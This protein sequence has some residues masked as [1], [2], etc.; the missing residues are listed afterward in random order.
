MAP[1]VDSNGLTAWERR[2]AENAKVNNEILNES[3]N[4]GGKRKRDD[5]FV[6][7]GFND[8]PQAAAATREKRLRVRGDLQLSDMKVD[9]RW[10]GSLDG[11]QGLAK[12][13]AGG[14][15]PGVRTFTDD[16]IQETTDKELKRLR[17]EMNSLALYDKFDV[18]DL[19]L[20]KER[21]YA[22]AFHPTEDKPLVFAGDKEGRLGIFDA[23]Q[24]PD[25]AVKE[26][27]ADDHE[28]PPEPVILGFQP[29]T[30]TISGLFCLDTDPS[31]VY[32]ASY[33]T[34][35]RKLDLHA[36]KSVEVYAPADGDDSD[37]AIS[38]MDFASDSPH[39]VFFS[40]L[41]GALGRHDLRAAPQTAELW[42]ALHGGHKI[43]GFSLSP[44]QPHLVATASLDRTLK[45]WDLRKIAAVQHDDDDDDTSTTTLRP[46]LLGEDAARLSVSHAA[47]GAGGQIAT[48]SYDDTIR[49]YDVN[50][51]A[52]ATNPGQPL[53]A[54]VMTPAHNIRHNNQT[55]R[56]VTILKPQWQRRPPGGFHKFAVGNMN[57]FVDVYAANGEQLGQ[58][59]G[60]GITAVPAVAHFHPSQNWVAGGNASGK[61]TLWM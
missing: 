34:T 9:G 22:M 32:T 20:T 52:A 57:R 46:A 18:K 43:G 27:D 10:Q 54:S 14:A 11:L 44:R 2:R 4:A 7:L 37:R 21:I 3:D 38:C 29:H 26:E 19:K 24:E 50:A 16:D 59:D 28:D 61:L 53:P 8:L 41:D 30:R 15:Q 1:A 55:G 47:W 42:T 51:A 60:D 6:E 35:I 25:V 39:L 12:L 31:A 40:T 13:P 23:S 33:D 45:I 49:V 5:A 48:T 17:Q 58:L 36:Q 56:W